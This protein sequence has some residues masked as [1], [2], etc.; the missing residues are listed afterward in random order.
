VATLDGRVVVG[1]S[2]EGGSGAL[3]LLRRDPNVGAGP[4][5]RPRLPHVP[6]PSLPT[7]PAPVATVQALYQKL[8]KRADVRELLS[9][10]AKK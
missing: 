6:L 8:T 2:Y 3:P 5:H 7:E 1:R 10:L 9:R 4:A